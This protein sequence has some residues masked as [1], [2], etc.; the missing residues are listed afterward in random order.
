LGVADRIDGGK[1]DALVAE[2]LERPQ[3]GLRIENLRNEPLH[4]A[5]LSAASQMAAAL[6]HD[7]NQPLTAIIN[8]VNAAKRLLAHEVQ[9]GYW[10]TKIASAS[11]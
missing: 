11:S 3:A 2:T 8:S 5:R 4:I 7:L 6:T 9:S 10:L 1:Q